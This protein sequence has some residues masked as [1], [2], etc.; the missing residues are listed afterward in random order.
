MARRR[1]S[2]SSPRPRAGSVLQASSRSRSRRPRA[3]G[4]SRR[5]GGGRGL[6]GVLR[7]LLVV[8]VVAAVVVGGVLLYRA[9]TGNTVGRRE[10]AQRYTT[11]WAG[12]QWAV[13][14]QNLTPAAR[15]AYPEARFTAAYRSA[16][17]AAGVRSVS[18]VKLGKENGGGIPVAVRVGTL[19]FGTLA[20]TIVLPVSGSDKTAGVDWSPSLRLPGL[21]PG[22]VVHRLSG[23]QPQRA[24][25][26]AADGSPLDA[27][28]LGAGIAG[29]TSPKLTGLQRIYDRRLAG[30]PSEKLLYGKRVI[31][32]V[33]EVAG[34]TLTTTIKPGLMAAAANALGAQLGGVAVMRPSDGA[35]LATAGLA[36]SAPQPPGSTFKI[37]T[38]STAL[39]DHVATP[40]TTFP[41]ASAATLAGVQLRNA[42]GEVCGGTLTQAFI[43]S[44]NSVFAPLGAKIGA[45]RLV[46]GARAFGFD[47]QPRIPAAKPSTI[48][49]P[50]QLKDD[51]AVGAAAIGQD[52]DL[53]TPLEMVSAGATIANDGRRIRPRIATIDPIVSRQVVSPEVAHEV[54][55][56]MI[57]VVQSGTGTAAAIPG[58][59]VAGKT[60]TAELVP[61]SSNPKD[62]D[63]WFVAFAP[64]L[65]PKV[66]VGVMLVGAGFG[67]A[68]AAPIARQVLEAALAGR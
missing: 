61:N 8:L 7:V 23:P 5:A 44:C 4:H 42:G 34:Q 38:V 6:G 48:S 30:H 39:Q 29:A 62:S 31:A 10:A 17:R 60:G 2:S 47:E 43:I 56:M 59:T 37:I 14:W 13:M 9:L 49:P 33:P 16:Y 36:V 25:I 27:T 32:S 15:A 45:K 24:S 22:E 35:L 1:S 18:I 3:G 68:T 20:G 50:A 58:V 12:A 41:D 51:L 40:S 54:R 11:A 52:K 26:L 28:A 53:A 65:N 66:A 19:D 64:A 57:G 63:A 21:R 67:G 55:S 46:A